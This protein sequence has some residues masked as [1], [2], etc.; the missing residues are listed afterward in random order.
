MLLSSFKL[1]LSAMQELAK[2][3]WFALYWNT[4]DTNLMNAEILA[5]VK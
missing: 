2:I 4:I 1:W 5:T 3:S